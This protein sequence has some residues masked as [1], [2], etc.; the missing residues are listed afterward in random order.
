MSIIPVAFAYL[1]EN[2]SV[3]YTG[4]L[5]GPYP[6]LLEMSRYGRIGAM[7]PL[8]TEQQHRACMVVLMHKMSHL[9]DTDF[10]SLKIL[11]GKT[12]KE[13]MK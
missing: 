3:T 9:V 10:E 12:L 2:S 13:N 1:D 11:I 8:I 4:N 5:E 7:L 6:E